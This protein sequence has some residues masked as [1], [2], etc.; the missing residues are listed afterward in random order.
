MA[1]ALKDI[2][3]KIV[4]TLREKGFKGSG[5]NY[6]HAT[7]VAVSVVNFQKSSGGERFYVNVGVQPLFVPTESESAPDAKT[8]KE[9]ECIFRR[10]LDPPMDDLFGWPYST[11]IS[12]DLAQRF[13]QLYVSFIV[14]LMT[15]PGP[16]T[17]AI[18]SDFR[19][20]SAHLLFGSRHARNFLHLAR[21]LLAMGNCGRAA[22]FATAAIEICPPHAST[23]HY[24][25]KQVLA[26]TTI[27][28]KGDATEPSDAPKS[29]V[30]RNFDA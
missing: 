29:P 24:H 11:D 17:D 14:P 7:D 13:G 2:L 8:I 21:I 22:E 20:D 26:K 23:L 5:Q 19:P 12:A 25:L 16:I 28:A 1:D 27:A 4:A 10:R 15:I 30:G 3:A 6:R 9:P 18:V